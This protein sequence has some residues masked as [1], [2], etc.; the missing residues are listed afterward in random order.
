[1]MGMGVELLGVIA[2]GI[3]TAAVLFAATHAARKFGFVIAAWLLPAGIGFAMIGY[4][5]W[6]DY[7]WQDRAIARLP[8]GTDVLMT[9]TARQ[10]WAPWTYLVPAPVRFAALDPAATQPEPDGSTRAE[11][12][13]VERRGR[14]LVVPQMFDC[15]KGMI[16][17][18]R[19]TWTQAAPDDPAYDAVCRK[20]QG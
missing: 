3:G 2:V 17:P 1:M 5:V 15:E 11:I 18:A 10:P 7:T 9:G 6:N 12:I 4:S 14:T 19:G 13:L 16:R 8:V 20:P